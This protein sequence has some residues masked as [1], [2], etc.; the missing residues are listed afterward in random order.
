[1]VS[2]LVCVVVALIVVRI[3]RRSRSRASSSSYFPL[4]GG[5]DSAPTKNIH[6]SRTDGPS[7]GNG[8]TAAATIIRMLKNVTGAPSPPER[9]SV[10]SVQA[11]PPQPPPLV[12]PYSDVNSSPPTA[13]VASQ[14]TDRAS[15]LLAA[16]GSTVVAPE[17]G[18]ILSTGP[19][20]PYWRSGENG[21]PLVGLKGATSDHDDIDKGGQ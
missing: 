13:P 6:E 21:Q 4:A 18:A 15:S 11:Q 1:M 19:V 12:G 14:F 9:D 7:P 2:V 10:R 3:R 20:P 16:S 17:I 8:T 5:D